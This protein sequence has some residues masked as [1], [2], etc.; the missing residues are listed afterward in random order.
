MVFVGISSR[1]GVEY[2][3]W[4]LFTTHTTGSCQMAETFRHSCQ[5][6]FDVAPSPQIAMATRSS[7]RFLYAR[8]APAACGYADGW[9]ER[10]ANMRATF[11]SPKCEVHAQSNVVSTP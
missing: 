11:Q 9:F 7:P 5:R 1:F 4:L 8:A 3:N 6:P 2:A 10:Y